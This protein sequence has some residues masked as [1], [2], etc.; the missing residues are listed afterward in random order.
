MQNHIPI[1]NFL[2]QVIAT[3]FQKKN[4]GKYENEDFGQTLGSYGVT[5][6]PYL[7]IP[8]LGPSTTR[9]FGGYM[10]DRAIDPVSFNLLAF[11]G[12][13]T[14]IDPWF[15]AGVAFLYNLDLRES[16]LDPIAD[17]RKDSF[18]LYATLRS[19]YVQQRDLKILK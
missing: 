3:N 13:P 4:L 18:D 14:A 12:S 11:G 10:F 8:L 9:D 19:V 5:S 6:G 16:L 7:M 17:A 2:Y 15:L 1:R